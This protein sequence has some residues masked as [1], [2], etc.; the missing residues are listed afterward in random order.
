ME[1]ER[2]EQLDRH[3]TVS[4]RAQRPP[5]GLIKGDAQMTPKVLSSVND[6][7][8]KIN[9]KIRSSQGQVSS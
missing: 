1:L 3:V 5:V 7:A 4:G 8:T 6:D 2:K 9:D